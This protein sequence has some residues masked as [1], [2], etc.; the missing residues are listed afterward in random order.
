MRR[1]IT[2]ERELLGYWPMIE[3]RQSSRTPISY[4]ASKLANLHFHPYGLWKE[5]GMVRFYAPK[6]SSHVS[7]SIVNLQNTR[8]YFEAE[9]RD[10]AG[11]MT[12]MGHK[13]VTLLKLDVEGAEYE[14]PDSLIAADIYPHIICV[15]FDEGPTPRNEGYPQRISNAIKKIKHAG[16]SATFIDGWNVTFVAH[17]TSSE[18]P[19]PNVYS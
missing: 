18:L 5:S 4:G 15:E 11:I 10:M 2:T 8:D 6:N 14:I 7:H 12:A 17:R 16:C 19:Q 1:S 9:C 13:D 3:T